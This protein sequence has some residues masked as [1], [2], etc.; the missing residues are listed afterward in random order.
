M[1]LDSTPY[2][3]ARSR[4]GLLERVSWTS[5]VGRNKSNKTNNGKIPEE[6]YLIRHIGTDW[7]ASAGASLRK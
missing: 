2:L 3:P 5:F 4:D 6:S 1:P 7:Y